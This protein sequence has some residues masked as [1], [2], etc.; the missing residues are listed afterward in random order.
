M[1]LSLHSLFSQLKRGFLGAEG[2][3]LIEYALLGAL[4]SLGAVAG[5]HNVANSLIAS[6]NHLAT[7]FNSLV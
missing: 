5:M 3:D 4:V 7:S 1:V 2:Q 6:Y